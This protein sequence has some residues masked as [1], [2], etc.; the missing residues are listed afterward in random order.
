[1]LTPKQISALKA[2]YKIYKTGKKYERKFI[3]GVFYR[4]TGRRLGKAYHGIPIV[5]ALIN[6]TK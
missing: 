1:M 2:A 3:E 4:T 6:L 5:R